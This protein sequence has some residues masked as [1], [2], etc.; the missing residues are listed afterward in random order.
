M[1]LMPTIFLLFSFPLPGRY[2]SSPWN[3]WDQKKREAIKQK[4]TEAKRKGKE[5]ERMKIRSKS[6]H[7]QRALEL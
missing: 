4:Q 6:I 5:D 7:L 3:G 2:S 1:G